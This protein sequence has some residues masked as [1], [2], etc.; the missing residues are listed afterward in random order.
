MA[1]DRRQRGQYE[2]DCPDNKLLA[3][4]GTLRGDVH[5]RPF[6]SFLRREP[7]AGIVAFIRHWSGKNMAFGW[8]LGHEILSAKQEALNARR[9]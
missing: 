5:H 1:P 4:F 6:F 8:G 2:D 9:S 7:T 3:P